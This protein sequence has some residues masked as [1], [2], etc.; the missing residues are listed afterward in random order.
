[1][2]DVTAAL[3]GH[4]EKTFELTYKLWQQRNR[5]FLLLLAV[6]STATFLSFR[7][8][9]GDTLLASWIANSAGLTED[10]EIVALRKSFPYE[11]LQTI[12]LIVIFYLMVN[13]YHRAVYVLRNYRYLGLL[14]AEIRSHLNLDANS[15]SF[16][17]ESTFYWDQRSVLS[18]GVKFVY[19]GILGA[20]LIAFLFAQA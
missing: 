4:Y 2:P 17:R 13:L 1:M 8:P 10:T 15:V 14:E 5:L 7:T 18:G 12:L 16:T 20:L 19:I 6:I 9:F 11:L 3:V